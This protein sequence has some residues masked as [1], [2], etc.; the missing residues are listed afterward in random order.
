MLSEVMYYSQDR[1]R[2]FG[3]IQSAP[4][5]NVK[6]RVAREGMKLHPTNAYDGIKKKPGSREPGFFSL[7]YL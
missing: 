7:L 1:D 2:W 5:V 4:T 3:R 6:E